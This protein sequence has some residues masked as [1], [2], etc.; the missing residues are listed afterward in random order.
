MLVVDDSA[1]VRSLLTRMLHSDPRLRVIGTAASGA[2]A[3][4]LARS[5]RPDVITMDIVMPGM[6]GFAAARRIMET[7]P[8]PIVIVTGTANIQEVRTAFA[9]MEA[10]ALAVL[11][12]PPGPEDADFARA[13]GELVRTVRAMAGVRVVHRYPR[14]GSEREPEPVPQ[15]SEITVRAIGIGASTGGPLA[16]GELLAAL[17]PGTTVPILI[18]QHIASGFLGGFADWLSSTSGHPVRIARDGERLT[19]GMI[20]LAPDGRHLELDQ[21]ERLRVSVGPPEHGVRPSASVLLRSLR[22]SLGPRAAGVL[23]SGMGVDGV[24]E[25]ARL[26]AAGGLTIVQDPESAIV[27]GMPGAAVRAGAADYVISPV[28]IGALI[29]TLTPDPE[30]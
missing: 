11:E 10:G 7:V 17:P 5:L 6:D 1:V 14:R 9:A 12:K 4:A 24:D 22:E 26:R 2:E 27:N 15:L 19:P 30:R 8:T 13:S 21:D 20:R 28:G 29:G 16:L 23:L 3:V 25:L 18:V